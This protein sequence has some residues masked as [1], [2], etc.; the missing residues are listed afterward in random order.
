LKGQSSFDDCPSFLISTEKNRQ[1]KSAGA[2]SRESFIGM[3][4]EEK[5]VITKSKQI[6]RQ[7][8]FWVVK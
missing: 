2:K 1:N 7:N 8:I 4:D 3:A 5:H 6:C